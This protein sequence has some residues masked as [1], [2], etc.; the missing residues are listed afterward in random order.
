MDEGQVNGSDEIIDSILD[1]PHVQKI[2]E[3]RWA[4]EYIND[5][6]NRM[7]MQQFQKSKNA[8]KWIHFARDDLAGLL[9]PN[10]CGSLSDSYEAFDYVKNVDSFSNW[11]KISIQSLGAVA[12]YFAA[13][14]IKC[15]STIPQICFFLFSILSS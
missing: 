11:Q 14:K 12:M 2:L 7:N 13:S 15:E 5:D 6:K 3:A 4:E 1:S 10:I 8:Q 9:Y